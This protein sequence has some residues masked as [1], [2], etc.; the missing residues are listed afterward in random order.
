MQITKSISG[1]VWDVDV[2]KVEETLV[3]P[4][5]SSQGH[6]FQLEVKLALQ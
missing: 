2:T 6:I 3:A 4:F 5:P 1:H